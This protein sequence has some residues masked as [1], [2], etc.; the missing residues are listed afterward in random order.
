MS[1]RLHFSKHDDLIC[2]CFH[3]IRLRACIF[4]QPPKPKSALR[5]ENNQLLEYTTN[6]IH[7]CGLRTGDPSAFPR[8]LVF[9]ETSVRLLCTVLFAC[10]SASRPEELRRGEKANGI[11]WN[12]NHLP[13]A[14]AEPWFVR[15]SLFRSVTDVLRHGSHGMEP[16]ELQ[17]FD[18]PRPADFASR[19]VFL[20]EECCEV[21]W[22]SIAR[23]FE[24]CPRTRK[25]TS[26]SGRM[27]FERSNITS[28][29]P[30][31]F[32]RQSLEH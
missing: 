24:I 15:P 29:D 8:P 32:E 26:C 5:S 22:Q 2:L 12:L 10:H 31:Y 14:C 17:T 7:A 4:P 20:C 11:N 19:L 21:K 1:G 6:Q 9:H 3:F 30:G 13:S 16:V 18:R 23:T 28:V 27:T 25:T